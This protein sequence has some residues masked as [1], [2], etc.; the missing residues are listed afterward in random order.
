MISSF[1]GKYRFLSNFHPCEIDFGGMKFPSVENAYQAAKSEDP[2][3]RAK[4]VSVDAKTAKKL[5][6]KISLR[7]DWEIV[8]LDVM[9]DLVRQKFYNDEELRN[10][11]LDTGE[12]E[13]IEGNWW[14]D[15]FWGQCPVG[16]GQNHLGNILMEVRDELREALNKGDE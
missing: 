6:N 7:E 4:F 5:G 12:D 9:G 2:T 16:N 13:L 3:E 8:K 15:R 1:G 14:G 11:L 10:K